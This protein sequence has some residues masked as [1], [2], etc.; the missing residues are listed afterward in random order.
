MSTVR[1]FWAVLERELR[2]ALRHRAQ[3]LQALAFF[4]LI[5]ALFPLGAR[6]EAALLRPFAPAILWMAALVSTVISLD[7]LFV[8][9]AQDGSLEQLLLSPAPISLLLLAKVLAHWLTGGLGVV[10]LSPLLGLALGLPMEVCGLAMLTLALG[11]PVLTLVGGIGA[12]LTVGLRSGLLLPLILLPL[13]VPVL[14]FGAQSLAAAAQ[15]LPVTG[16]L[17]MLSALLVLA[18]TLAPLAMAA[19]LKISLES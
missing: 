11:T 4:V 15:G 6:P 1:I 19:A 18:L 12:A 2:T 9:D 13:Y 14:I 8:A 7:R 10:V 17:Y 16:A 3:W 5:V